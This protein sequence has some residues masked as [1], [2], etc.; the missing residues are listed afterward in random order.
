MKRVLMVCYYF[1]PL[2]AVS[3]L[4]AVKLATLLPEFGWDVRVLAPRRGAYHHDASLAFPEEKVARTASLELSR[5]G[6]RAISAGASDDRPAPVGPVSRRL[7]DV[8]RRFLYRPDP[9]VGWYPFAVRAGRRVLRDER[10]DALFSSSVPL[11]AHKIAQRL[12]RDF[13]LP[14]I[15]EFRDPWADGVDAGDP[16]RRRREAEEREILE[17]ASAIVTVSPDWARRFREKGA[18]DVA[19]ITNGFDPEDLPPPRPADGLVLTHVG[20]FYPDRQDL[21]TLWPALRKVGASGHAW[22][23]RFVGGLHPLLAAELAEHGLADRLEVKGFLPHLEAVRELTSSSA[24]LVA[25]SRDDRARLR[26][27]IPAK[28][29]EY[30]ASGLPVLYLGDPTTDAARI[31]AEQPGCHVVEPG[32]VQGAQQALLAAARGV[33][34]ERDLRRFTHRALAGQLAGL[35]DRV[36]A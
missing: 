7:R 12:R 17:A 4:R 6:K 3:S 10:F 31:L 19:V 25:G 28:I 27:M 14:W 33:R 24:L 2:G 23:L 16:L 11:T 35:L 13:G 34:F 20:N 22:R 1:P 9:Q 15:A 29:F 32:D 5:M 26:G 21:S 18:R 36:V 30:L 8:A